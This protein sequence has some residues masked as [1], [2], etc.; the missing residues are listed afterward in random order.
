MHVY[1]T[2]GTERDGVTVDMEHI[3][4]VEDDV[5]LRYL[6]MEIDDPDPTAEMGSKSGRYT[7]LRQ[8]FGQHEGTV[9][10]VCRR[11]GNDVDQWESQINLGHITDMEADVI[12]GLR[13]GRLTVH[14]AI[15]AEEESE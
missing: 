4:S 6:G 10:T 5:T 1:V 3:F 13:E 14:W 15:Q 12:R 11:N 8:P 9:H 2:L 7:V